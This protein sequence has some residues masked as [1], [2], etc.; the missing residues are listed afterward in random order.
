MILFKEIISQ[1]ILAETG[2]SMMKML[3]RLITCGLENNTLILWSVLFPKV[4][5]CLI[6]K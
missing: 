2:F 5:L 1:V 4:Q 3:K 6:L